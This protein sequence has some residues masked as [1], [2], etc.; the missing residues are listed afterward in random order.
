[1][2]GPRVPIALVPPWNADQ[3]TLLAFHAYGTRSYLEVGVQEG[4]SLRVV[5]DNCPTLEH[6]ALCDTWGTESG[7]S[8]RGSSDHLQPI[9]TLVQP[10]ARISIHTGDSRA[11]LPELFDPFDLVHIDGGHSYEVALSDLVNGWRLCRSTMIVHDISFDEVWRA[12]QTFVSGTNAAD[13]AAIHCYFGGHG[14]AV[15]LR[16]R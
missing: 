11:V 1:M 8:G 13:I 12:F 3:R 7:G 10:N 4:R 9:L 5:I 16:A 6:L 2:M 15:I 14:T